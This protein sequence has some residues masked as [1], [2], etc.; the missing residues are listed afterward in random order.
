MKKTPSGGQAERPPETNTGSSD[1]QVTR[2]TERITHLSD[3]LKGHPKDHASR[4]GLLQMVSHRAALLGYLARKEP[5]RHSA[6][7]NTLGIRK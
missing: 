5:K 4:R 2:L 7:L 3:H 6:L 1:Y